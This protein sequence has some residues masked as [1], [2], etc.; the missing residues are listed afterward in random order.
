LKVVDHL[1][2]GIELVTA[3]PERDE[4]ARLNLMA[5]QKS[6]RQLSPTLVAKKYLATA[7]DGWQ[8]L[9]GKPTMT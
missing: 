1:N 3:Q 9:A 2:H 6:K 8:L 4:I 7:R 5:G